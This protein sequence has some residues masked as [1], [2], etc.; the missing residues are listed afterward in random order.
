MNPPRFS[1]S[2]TT[3]KLKNIMENL[4]NVFEVMHMVDGEKVELVSYELKNMPRTR[5]N[6]WKGNRDDNAPHS[7][8]VCFEEAF[9]GRLIPREPKKA[10]VWEF[11]TLEQDS[12]SVHEY[13]LKFT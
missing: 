9:L 13:E 7:S 11:L 8:W 10:E 12:L 3:E 5:F 1:D 4:K 2:R 6:Q